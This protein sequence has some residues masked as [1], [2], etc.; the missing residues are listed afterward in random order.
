MSG[1]E[2][3]SGLTLC[4]AITYLRQQREMSARAL[5]EAAGFSPSYVGK[6]EAGEV[7]PSFKAFCRLAK[8]LNLSDYEIVFL[9]KRSQES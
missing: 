4:S 5:S 3:L 8:A 1:K 6:L 7:Q 9:V 2:S